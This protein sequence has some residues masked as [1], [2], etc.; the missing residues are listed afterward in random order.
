MKCDDDDSQAA[1]GA[2]MRTS[3]SGHKEQR[4]ASHIAEA[5]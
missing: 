2:Q 3:D 4:K 5:Q 1:L